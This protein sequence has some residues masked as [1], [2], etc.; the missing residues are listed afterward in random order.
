MQED[1]SIRPAQP[2]DHGP[3]MAVMP[4]WWG[5]RD[6]RQGLPRLFLEHFHDTSFIVEHQGRMVGFLVA[7]LS[8]ARPGE[9]YVHFM[10][11]DPAYQGQDIGRGLYERFFALCRQ[12]G[13]TVVRACTSLVNRAS[14]GFHQKLGFSLV[15]GD[16]VL[17]GIPYINDYNLPGDDKV[18]FRKRLDGA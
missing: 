12:N 17:D 14:I 4:A 6:L 10:G 5:G 18:E 13:R 9:G 2:S 15:P 11:V 8:P 3:I 16:G 1:L 7:F